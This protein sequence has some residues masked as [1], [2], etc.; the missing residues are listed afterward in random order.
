MKATNI[1]GREIFFSASSSDAFKACPRRWWF[2]KVMMQTEPSDPS[3]MFGTAV[4]LVLEKYLQ[5]GEIVLAD[6]AQKLLKDPMVQKT[7]LGV[8]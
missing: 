1:E 2:A 4:H 6:D 5:T 8:E 7:Y 3:L